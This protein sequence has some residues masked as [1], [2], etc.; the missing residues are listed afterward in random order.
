MTASYGTTGWAAAGG[1]DLTTWERRAEL[2]RALRA[3]LRASRERLARRLGLG[4]RPFLLALAEVPLPRS[5]LADAAHQRLSQG[6]AWNLG[7]SLRSYLWAAL[8]AKRDGRSFDAELLF[9]ACALHDLGLV[10]PGPQGC[11][12]HRGAELARVCCLSA[13]APPERAGAVAEAICQHLNV[14]PSA[15]SAEAWLVRAGSGFDVIGDR[16]FDLAPETRQAVHQAFPRAGFAEAVT[17]VLLA[18]TAAHPGTRI[19]FLCQALRFPALVK[20]ADGWF[21]RDTR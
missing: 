20:R 21:R 10:E 1:G 2:L 19:A 16:F 12:S 18:E 17:S 13:G 8:L 3:Q 15:L 11:F 5:P 9:A 6:P 4:P 14:V 7:H